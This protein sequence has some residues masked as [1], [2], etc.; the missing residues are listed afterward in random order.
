MEGKRV[1]RTKCKERWEEVYRRGMKVKKKK[2][3]RDGR[4]KEG[5]FACD[6]WRE[7]RKEG[8]EKRTMENRCRIWIEER[9]T[10]KG[11]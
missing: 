10:G 11:K 3:G 6:R 4:R 9:K 2:G 8:R 7:R 1:G 5:N